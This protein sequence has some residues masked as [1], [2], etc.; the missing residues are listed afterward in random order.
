[1][2]KK[3]QVTN[4]YLNG[5]TIG[6][7]GVEDVCQHMIDLCRQSIGVGTEIPHLF[8]FFK[9]LLC[10]VEKPEE[11][12]FRGPRRAHLCFSVIKEEIFIGI[13]P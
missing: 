12:N 1:M 11:N 10:Q 6:P 4:E 5:Y 13:T 3:D 9:V 7:K 8:S 2:Q